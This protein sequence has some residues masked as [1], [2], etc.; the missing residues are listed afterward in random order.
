M[1][2]GDE[3]WVRAFKADSS[4]YRWWR[5]AI[6]QASEECIITYTRVGNAIFHN[7]AK[8]RRVILH[9]RHAIRTYY[10][11]GRR[12]NLLEVYMPDGRLRE[13]Y[14]DIISPIQVNDG[15]IHYIDHEL[16]VQMYAGEKPQIIDQDEFAEA[17]EL[18]GYTGEFYQ[19]SFDLAVQL[20]DVLE[21]WQPAG[22][23]G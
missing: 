12:H 15:E 2:P 1:K 20:L 16:D 3:L 7:P 18:F 17:A 8:F 9:Q 13:L 5:A 4:P 11:P 10:W 22:S 6:E 23:R 21:A 19:A 14:I